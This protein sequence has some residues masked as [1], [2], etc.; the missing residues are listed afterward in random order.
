[1]LARLRRFI[2]GVDVTFEPEWDDWLRADYAHWSLPV[3]DDIRQRWQDLTARFVALTRWEPA[4]GLELDDRMR[5]SIAAQATRLL[6]GVEIDDFPSLGTVLVRRSAARISAPRTIGRSGG[7]VSGSH[8][9]AGQASH[10]GQIVLVWPVVR[11]GASREQSRTNVVYHEFA[12]RLDMSGGSTDGTPPL[13]R[14]EHQE[15]WAEV[16]QVAYERVETG[17]SMLR[18]YAATNPAEFFAV[19][20]EAFFCQPDELAFHEPVVYSA[21][22]AFYRQDPAALTT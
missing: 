19:A 22:R 9:I 6:L 20:T 7:V 2:F 3:D 5:V 4:Q 21:L 14:R 1:M 15:R 10:D 17:E 16:M 18:G 12:H 13:G 8:H 11:Q